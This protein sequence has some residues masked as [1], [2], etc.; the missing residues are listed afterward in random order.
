MEYSQDSES[1]LLGRACTH[2]E[3]GLCV[4]GT[5]CSMAFSAMLR[6]TG[7]VLEAVGAAD[8]NVL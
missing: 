3:Q 4:G 5:R 7:L 1:W 6:I 8:I 2:W